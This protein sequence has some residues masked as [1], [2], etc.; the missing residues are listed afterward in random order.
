MSYVS[1]YNASKVYTQTAAGVRNFRLLQKNIIYIH[2]HT[3]RHRHTHL[4]FCVSLYI[5]TWIHALNI[6]CEDT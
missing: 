5:V 3:H 2:M 6:Q 4:C 1:Y